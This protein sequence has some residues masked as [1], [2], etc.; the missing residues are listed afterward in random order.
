MAQFFVDTFSGL[1]TAHLFWEDTLGITV[2]AWPFFGYVTIA[3]ALVAAWVGWSKSRRE[4][5]SGKAAAVLLFA[6]LSFIAIFAEITITPQ[7][8]G[9]HHFIMLFPYP[10]MILVGMIFSVWPSGLIEKR[11]PLQ[12]AGASL[13]ALLAF[14]F[15]IFDVTASFRHFSA[16]LTRTKTN[17]RWN[18]AI[19]TLAQSL[20]KSDANSIVVADWG[21]ANQLYCY[22]GKQAWALPKGQPPKNR[23][24]KWRTLIC[25]G[26]MR[27]REEERTNNPK[28]ALRAMESEKVLVVSYTPKNAT[29]PEIPRAISRVMAADG[30]PYKQTTIPDLNGFPLYEIRWIGCDPK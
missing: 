4:Q 18:P 16:N 13:F 28:E 19:S 8:G 24:K 11:S 21:I 27:F 23:K 26:Y 2:G 25:D 20:L 14:A 17:P 15:S 10:Q 5:L 29:F 7:A 12:F 6:L 9:P 3:G 1:A 22:F 30:R